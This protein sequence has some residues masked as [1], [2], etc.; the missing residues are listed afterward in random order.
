M[1]F[2]IF[3]NKQ[4]RAMILIHGM[5]QPWQVWQPA[6]DHFSKTCCVIV[7]ELDGHTQDEATEFVSVWKEAEL[8]KDYLTENFGG[9]VF[10]ICGLGMGGRIAAIL[11]DM[12]DL[13]TEFLILDGAPLT[14]QGRVVKGLMKK[15]FKVLITK[16]K[17][18]DPAA[19]EKRENPFVPE[20][21]FDSYL[22]VIDNMSE[23]SLNSMID[24]TYRKFEIP[25]YDKSCKIM[26]MHGTQKS[27]SLS[28]KSAIKMKRKNP[29]AR[30][31][32]FEGYDQ[33]QLA[34]F[35]EKRWIAEV[36]AFLSAPSKL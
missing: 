20:R 10:A 21:C 9:K 14:S 32:M 8:I 1:K 4:N 31:R 16:T 7:P 33:N 25:E 29:Q 6:I 17:Q 34:C 28:K 19:I 13:S 27:E 24:T 22:K 18:R 26:V 2:H 3:G 5:I 35:D 36:S 15:L 30:L 11:G 12:K 23:T